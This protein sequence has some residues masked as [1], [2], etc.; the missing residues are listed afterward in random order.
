MKLTAKIFI[1]ILLSGTLSISSFAQK[2]YTYSPPQTLNDGWSTE[3]LFNDSTDSA[4]VYGLFNQLVTVKHKVHSALLIHKGNLVLEEYYG[5]YGIND[6]HDL[7]STTKSVRSLLLGIAIDKGFIEDI[8]D[9]IQKY[10]KTPVA[11]KNVD[12]RKQAITIRHLLTMSSG[13][14]CN[15]WDKKSRGQEDKVYKKKNWLQFTLDLPM[16]NDPGE[17]AAYCSMGVVLATEAI[18]QAS[19]M[20]IDEFAHRYLFEPL[21]ISNMSWG[22]TSKRKNIPSSAKRLYMTPRDM[23]K[24][25]MLILNDGTWGQKQIISKEWI[26]EATTSHTQITGIDYGFWW[27]NIPFGTYTSISATGNGGQYIFVIPELDMV[28]V[29][30]GGAYNSQD[31]K[32]PFGIVNNI[33]IPTITGK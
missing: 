33:F 4:L 32:L 15:D 23:A 17:V 24:I 25:G 22:H 2:S 19:G 6:Q 28:A 3:H 9:P 8:D 10:V 11:K 29:F 16:I 20:E 21:G 26:D 14:D 30:T 31:D 12:E 1:G 13:L 27:W 18:R 5:D 7:R